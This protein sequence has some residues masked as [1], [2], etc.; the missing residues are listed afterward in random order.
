[1][2]DKNA[3]IYVAGHKGMVGSAIVRALNKEGYF[4][5]VTRKHF[6]VFF[7]N[8]VKSRIIVYSISTLLVASYIVYLIL[9]TTGVNLI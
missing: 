7:K 2:I 5:I 6:L 8:D 9:A 3:K 4:N 1:M